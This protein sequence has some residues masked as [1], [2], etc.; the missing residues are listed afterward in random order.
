MIKKAVPKTVLK[1]A[2]EPKHFPTGISD[3]IEIK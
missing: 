1:A 2:D 3:L